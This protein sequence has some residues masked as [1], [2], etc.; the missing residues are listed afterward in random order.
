MQYS[1]T[2]VF[3]YIYGLE[4]WS[5]LNDQFLHVSPSLE[6]FLLVTTE[7]LPIG[8]LACVMSFYT[9]LGKLEVEEKDSNEKVE[10]EEAS[11]QDENDEVVSI[12]WIG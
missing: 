8:L 1:S 5:S 3:R 10:E 12:S 4:V 2:F 6:F 9:L 7:L 11:N